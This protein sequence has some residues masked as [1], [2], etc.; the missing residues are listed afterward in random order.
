MV[1]ALIDDALAAVETRESL[2][3]GCTSLGRGI[4]ALAGEGGSIPAL[5]AT[6]RAE[7][8]SPDDKE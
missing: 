7:G 8:L 2:I 4:N 3:A 1:F 6:G 5:R